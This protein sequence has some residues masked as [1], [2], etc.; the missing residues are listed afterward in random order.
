MD[1]E[2]IKFG[3]RASKRE[4]RE[5]CR[6]QDEEEKMEK[7]L[8]DTAKFASLHDHTPMSREE[9][10]IEEVKRESL[11]CPPHMTK[12]KRLIEEVKRESLAAMQA[13]EESQSLPGE[14]HDIQEVP[15]TWRL[16]GTR[17]P[18]LAT[19]A[20]PFTGDVASIQSIEV[21]RRMPMEEVVDASSS[22]VSDRKPAAQDQTQVNDAPIPRAILNGEFSMTLGG[23]FGG[24][25]VGNT[26]PYSFRNC[27]EN[28]SS[29][30]E[31]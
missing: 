19:A 13:L 16:R 27:H 12:E 11:A 20:F 17:M 7:A 18:S 29:L 2:A 8:I 23:H 5:L 3:I 14:N 21:Y 15:S 1:D 6:R 10:I 26:P 25:N 24:D 4:F 9:C 22:S 30:S 28:D 31:R